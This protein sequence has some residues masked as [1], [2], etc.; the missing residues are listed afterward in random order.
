MLTLFRWLDFGSFTIY[1]D[2]MYITSSA[3]YFTSLLAYDRAILS[4]SS[5]VKFIMGLRSFKNASLSSIWVFMIDI[6]FSYYVLYSS[7]PY[8]L[9][10]W[11]FIVSFWILH[12]VKSSLF[13]LFKSSISLVSIWILL[14]KKS[15]FF[16]YFNSLSLVVFWNEFIMFLSLNSSTLGSCTT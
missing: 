1:V 7:K 10:S 11:F 14:C 15:I 13:P 8:F 2:L 16:Y 6:I 3:F 4:R 12:S 5:N 9:T